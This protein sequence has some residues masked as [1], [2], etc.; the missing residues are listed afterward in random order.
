[1]PEN[2]NKRN[3]SVLQVVISTAK[4]GVTEAEIVKVANGIMPQLRKSPGFVH[5]EIRKTDD[6]KWVDCLWW[7]SLE[8]G[9]KIGAAIHVSPEGQAM[10][11]ILEGADFTMHNFFP[12]K[13]Y[14]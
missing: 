10:F 2:T 14:D 5:R 1:M 4:P 3:S 12:V 13:V 7:E 6:G 9:E 11:A 8:A